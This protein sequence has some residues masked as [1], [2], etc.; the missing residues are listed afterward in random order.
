MSLLLPVSP[1]APP[2]RIARSLPM[3]VMVCPKR[4]EGLSP[5]KSAFSIIYLNITFKEHHRFSHSFPLHDDTVPL[6]YF[7]IVV[8]LG[9]YLPPQFH[10]RLVGIEKMKPFM[11]YISPLG[12]FVN[13][14]RKL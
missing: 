6:H 4:A 9:F 7:R 8:Y 10:L 13:S 14:L 11:L 5:V 2:K 1:T 3:G 12:I